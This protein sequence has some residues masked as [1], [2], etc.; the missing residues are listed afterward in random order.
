[1]KKQILFVV[2]KLTVGGITSSLVNFIDF[3]NEKYPD[4]FEIDLFTFS[5][6][7]RAENIPE[8]INIFHGNKLLEL[9]ATSFFD[10]LKSKKVLSIIMRVFLM[11][12]V[13]IIGS[14]SF[15]G[16]IL[17]KHINTKR[18]DIAI[19]YSN[20]VPGNYFNQGTN[21]YVADFTTAD[22]KIAWI[23]TDPVKMGFDKEHCEDVY[24]KYDRIICV[25]GAVKKSFDSLLPI[26]SDKTDVF[27]NVFDKTKILD[28]ASEYVPFDA[29]E[30]FNVVTVCRIDDETKRVDG[31]VRLCSRLK[32]EGIVDFKWRIVGS[33]P[34]LKR[35]MK[36]AKT[37][38]VLDV[39]EF[40]GEKKNPYPYISHS[41]LFALY[42]AYEGYP[43]V[44]GEAIATG[45]YILTTSYAAAAEQIDKTYGI[46]ASTDEDFYQKIKAIIELKEK[47]KYD[48]SVKCNSSHI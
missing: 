47:K 41:D 38:D 31:I 2:Q 24:R 25:S 4:A 15:Y 33:G 26:Y 44:I 23:H 7:K 34:S 48:T 40:V 17:E 14:D 28:K 11:I 5:S 21:R 10:V 19:S 37:L 6:L 9:S 22:E 18:Y 13:R 42:S 45:T 43:M 1:M 29:S 32:K 3:L 46:I 39:L 12:Y 35:N 27:Y 30:L 36:L 8:N 16:K 20:D